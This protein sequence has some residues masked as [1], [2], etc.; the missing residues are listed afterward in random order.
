MTNPAAASL[1][2]RIRGLRRWAAA[3]LPNPAT[4]PLDYPELQGSERCDPDIPGAT[5]DMR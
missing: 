2:P 3:S 5:R 4:S 1:N